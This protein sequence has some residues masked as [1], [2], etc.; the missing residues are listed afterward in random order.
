[1]GSSD[2]GPLDV[3]ITG[4]DLLL[5]AKVEAEELLPLGFAGSTF[6][7]AG[8]IGDFSTVEELAGKRLATS[9]AGL[10]RDYLAERGIKAAVVRLAGAAASPGRPGVPAGATRPLEIP[11]SKPMFG[12]EELEAIQQPLH[13]GWVVQGPFVARFEQRFAS[14]IDVAHAAATTSCTTALHLAVA[15]LGLKPG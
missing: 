13:S 3:G 2:L 15:V 12:P 14:H 1:V 11:I 6:R 4:R 7:F 10:P 8:P 5:D 9:Y